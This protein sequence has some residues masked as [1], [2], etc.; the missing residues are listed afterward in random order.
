MAF[1]M[2][3]KWGLDPNH[4]RYVGAH[5]PSTRWYHAPPPPR[6]ASLDAQ[7]PGSCRT[8]PGASDLRSLGLKMTPRVGIYSCGKG[9]MLDRY[10]WKSSRP[11]G[12]SKKYG[13][14][15]KSC[16]LI[17]FSIIFTIH[18]GVLL[19]LETSKWSPGIVD[20]I[21]SY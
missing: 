13:K 19:F 10:P 12:V 15:T 1:F 8:H 6:D 11:M 3:Y 21:N 4:L 18:F 7:K 5:P 16:I 2:A 20:E 17:G 14:T 9:L